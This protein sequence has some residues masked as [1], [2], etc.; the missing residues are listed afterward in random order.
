MEIQRFSRIQSDEMRRYFDENGFVIITDALSSED[1]A[2]FRAEVKN[3]ISAFLK[4]P[5]FRRSATKAMEFLLTASMPSK[6]PTTNMSLL[7]TTPYFKRLRF[8]EF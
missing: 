7:Y 8:S 6:R 2:D 1:I 3:V 5:A 4:K